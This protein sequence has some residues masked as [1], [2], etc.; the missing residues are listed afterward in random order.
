MNGHRIDPIDDFRFSIRVF[1]CRRR[2]ATLWCNTSS[3]QRADAE[4]TRAAVSCD[5]SLV[6]LPRIG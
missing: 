1:R 4:G 6:A 3:K 5:W 2:V